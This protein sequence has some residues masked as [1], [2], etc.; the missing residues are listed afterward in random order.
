[1]SCANFKQLTPTLLKKLRKAG[2]IK[3]IY[4]LESAS[5]KL[6]KYIHKGT[7]ILQVEN[8]LEESHKLGIWNELELISGIP[9]ETKNDEKKTIEFIKRNQ[10]FIDYFHVAKYI[11]MNSAIT[12][13]PKKYG[14]KGE[15]T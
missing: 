11:L 13:N 4:G 2:G 15:K 6:L 9:Y 7:T 10:K 8:L 12:K 14:R 5:P 3:L 1:M